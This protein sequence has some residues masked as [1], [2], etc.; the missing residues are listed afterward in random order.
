M[1]KVCRDSIPLAFFVLHPAATRN[2]SLKAAKLAITLY[3]RLFVYMRIR[4]M[5]FY[6]AISG[7]L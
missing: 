1:I 6:D 5:T 4:D 3:S 2:R 7:K